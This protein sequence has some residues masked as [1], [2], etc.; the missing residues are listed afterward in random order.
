M[1]HSLLLGCLT[2]IGVSCPSRLWFEN[3]E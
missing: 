2:R 1:D 3:Y